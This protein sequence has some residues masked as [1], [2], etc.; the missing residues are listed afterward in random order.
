M[1]PVDIVKSNL[2][3]YDHIKPKNPNGSYTVIATINDFNT[4]HLLALATGTQANLRSSPDIIQDCHAESL[5]KRAYKRYLINKIMQI[6]SKEQL[7]RD[8][9]VRRIKEDCSQNLTLFV[10]QFPCGFVRRY[11]GEEPVDEASGKPIKRKPGRGTVI[12][13][14]VV[15]V[16]KDPCFV[17]LQNWINHGIQGSKLNRIFNIRSDITRIIIGNCE[18]DQHF[19]YESHASTFERSILNGGRLQADVVKTVR[20]EEFLCDSTKQPQPVNLAWWSELH[21]HDEIKTHSPKGDHDL[22]VEGLRRGLTKRQRTMSESS[23]SLRVC[24][25]ILARDLQSLRDLAGAGI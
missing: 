13:G 8:D 24:G 2:K 16:E 18:L 23:K 5:V 7:K 19:D 14:R 9:L 17:K 25:R 1:N 11:E 15:Y 4:S 10:S 21:D 12:D 20:R 22:I 6:V 3:F